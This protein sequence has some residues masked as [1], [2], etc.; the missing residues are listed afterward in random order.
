MAQTSSGAGHRWH[1]VLFGTRPGGLLRARSRNSAHA[2]S[3]SHEHRPANNLGSLQVRPAPHL[4]RC[5]H[6]RCWNH[7]AV[8]KLGS[9]CDRHSDLRLLRSEGR[10]GRAKASRDLLRLRRLR[11]ANTQ[12]HSDDTQTRT[13]HL[14]LLR[15]SNDGSFRRKTSLGLPHAQCVQARRFGVAETR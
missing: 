12:I 15:R 7:T 5:P 4:H 10:L 14:K 11:D 2:E 8:G 1:L 13:S 9:C 6:G 3:G